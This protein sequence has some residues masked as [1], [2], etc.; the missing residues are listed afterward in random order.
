MYNADGKS[1]I[2]LEL[3]VCWLNMGLE[4]VQLD[5]VSVV[6]IFAGL[7]RNEMGLQNLV[8]VRMLFRL[9]V[10]VQGRT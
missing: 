7:V 3:E 5:A 10:R 4:T 8:Y 6:D 9:L 1:V 2:G